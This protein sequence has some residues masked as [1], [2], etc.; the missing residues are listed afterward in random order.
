MNKHMMDAAVGLRAKTGRAIAV[1]VGTPIDS[2][3][4]LLRTQL[5]LTDP[6]ALATSQ[7]YHELLDVPWEQAKKAVIETASPDFSLGAMAKL[8]LMVKV[9]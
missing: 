2:P 6:N 8:L 5:T 4:V 7:P 9:V 1:V 3:V